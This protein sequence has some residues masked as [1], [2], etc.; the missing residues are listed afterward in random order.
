MNRRRGNACCATT[1][2]TLRRVRTKIWAFL[3]RKNFWVWNILQIKLEKNVVQVYQALNW[4]FCKEF[5]SNCS[6]STSWARISAS[7]H[8]TRLA[9]IIMRL[10]ESKLMNFR[11]SLM[12]SNFF[13]L[14]SPLSLNCIREKLDPNHM[15]HYQNVQSFIDDCR[16]LF[17]NAYLY[18]TVSLNTWKHFKNSRT[19]DFSQMDSKTYTQAQELERFF[20]LQLRKL[21]P[22]YAKTPA[23]LARSS[24]NHLMVPMSLHDLID[25]LD[26]PKDDDYSPNNNPKRKRSTPSV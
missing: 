7:C 2:Q 18:Y 10:F 5:Y 13:L 21:L 11:P 20:E 3:F 8:H 22:K 4:R 17:D 12:I 14:I 25:D 1:S 9:K 23:Q 24:Q 6:V 19:L 15:H 26:D 16:L